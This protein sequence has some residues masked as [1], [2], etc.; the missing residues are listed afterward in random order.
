MIIHEK[1]DLFDF[2][3]DGDIILHNINCFNTWGSGFAKDA[4]FKLPTLFKVDTDSAKGDFRKLGT[5]ISAK[6][7]IDDK[8]VT[9]VAVY[10]QY[11]WSR[12]R[13]VLVYEKLAEALTLIN[14]ELLKD[15]GKITIKMP[16]IGSGTA[17]GDWEA[18]ENIIRGTLSNA[19][20]IIIYVL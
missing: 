10:G 18:I 2:V 9:G 16:R 14:D 8:E 4:K 17:G 12:E 5:Y 3:E 20:E 19:K 15:K 7:K 13:K 11:T 1:G 6:D